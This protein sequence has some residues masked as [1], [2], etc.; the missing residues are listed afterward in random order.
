[1]KNIRLHIKLT[2]NWRINRF[3]PLLRSVEGGIILILAAPIPMSR[4]R[5]LQTTG[6]TI[7]GGESGGCFA[8][9]LKS[10]EPSLVSQADNPP[11][12]SVRRIQRVYDFHGSIFISDHPVIGYVQLTEIYRQNSTGIPVL[13]L[14]LDQICNIENQTLG[15]VPSDARIGYG[16]SVYMLPN[17]LAP[18]FKITFYHEAFHHVLNMAVVAAGI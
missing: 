16:F 3:K 13:F 15:F 5:T 18:A 4:Y 17:F 14:R 12:D 9:V 8:Q 10:C 2:V 1:M 6:K 11:T 7:A